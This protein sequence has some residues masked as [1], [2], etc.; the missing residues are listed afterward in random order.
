MQVDPANVPLP[1]PSTASRTTPRSA[2]LLRSTPYIFLFSLLNC[3]LPYVTTLTPSLGLLP[4]DDITFTY[5]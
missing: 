1:T 5:L 3:P 4:L 2:M